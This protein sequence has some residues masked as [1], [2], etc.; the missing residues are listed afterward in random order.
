MNGKNNVTSRQMAV[1]TFFA[2]TGL[3]VII[4]PAT[5][6][7]VVG[8]DGWISM[9][10]AG[11][12]AIVFSALFAALLKRYG[13]K[14][15]YDINR[16]IFG[17]V[18]GSI[19]NVLLMAYLFLAAVR[20]VRV[21][22]LF[23]RLTVLPYTP[24]LALSPFI[25]LPSIYL[26][27]QGLKY[28]I[29]FKYISIWAYVLSILLIS[30]ILKDLRVSFLLPICEAGIGRLVSSIPTAF[31]HYMGLELIVF[32]FPE[33]TDKASAFRW[34]KA[35]ILSSSLYFALLVAICTALF[36]EN[37]LQIQTIPL[38]NMART[39]RA[40]ILERVDIYMVS[41]WL[42]VMGCSIRA[43]MFAAFYS[44]EKVFNLKRTKFLLV[45]YFLLIIAISRIPRDINEALMFLDITN[46][47]GI[48]VSLFLVLC[49]G[50]SFFR[51]K[52]VIT[53]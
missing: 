47:I 29:R 22:T 48:I 8:H 46:V 17:K 30:L 18:L 10:I 35:A 52:G 40:P 4:L 20:G 15:I 16:M 36:G 9:L 45:S 6:A 1:L 26:V 37:F 51:K 2:Q 44:L 31:M 33:I 34:Q 53:R 50:L 25:I 32:L 12:V 19:L 21:F 11:S 42:I 43:Y 14:G 3:G 28:V 49:L 24:A 41:L 39:Y 7:K 23:I 38:F 13:D 5:L 27:W